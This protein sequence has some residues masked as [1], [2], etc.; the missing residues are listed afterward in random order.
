M[1]YVK[2]LL[3]LHRWLLVRSGHRVHEKRTRWRW[4]W[5]TR[6]EK[7]AQTPSTSRPDPFSLPIPPTLTVPITADVHA[8]TCLP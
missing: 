7:K 4:N 1:S 8:L 5:E 3:V 2:K 6:K